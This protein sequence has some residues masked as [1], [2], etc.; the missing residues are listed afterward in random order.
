MRQS[1]LFQRIEAAAIFAASLFIYIKLDFS[2]LVFILLLFVFD[3]FMI[4]YLFNSKIGAYCY[5]L[6]HSMIAPPIL[7]AI[8]FATDTRILIGF[9]LI[10]FAHIGMDR[11][12]GYGLK[13]TSGFK[14]THLGHIGKK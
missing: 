9:S 12:L 7:F 11:F 6:G 10:W 2:I 5:N 13:F 14:E 8:G 4:G 3:V 1:L